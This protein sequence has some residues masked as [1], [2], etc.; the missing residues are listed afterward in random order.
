MSE[1]LMK[2]RFEFQLVADYHQFYL[3]DERADGDL[4]E[5]WSEEAVDRLL[6]IAPGTIEVGTVRDMD[7]LAVLEILDS[8]PEDHM[9]QWDQINECTIDLPSG[10]IVIAGCTDYFPGARR[11][12]VPTG[13]Y[14]AR[15][16]YGKLNTL[17]TDGLDGGD[18]YKVVLW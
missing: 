2:Q 15:V 14:R 16:Y 11:V 12:G 1:K 4:S 9:D 18:H 10:R 8:E 13:T 3:Q 5:S 6:A 7:V 17:S